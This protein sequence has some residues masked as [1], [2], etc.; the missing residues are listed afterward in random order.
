MRNTTRPV[1]REGT[2]VKQ[3]AGKRLDPDTKRREKTRLRVLQSDRHSDGDDDDGDDEQTDEETPPSLSPRCACVLCCLFYVLASVSCVSAYG[4]KGN[5][6][7]QEG[8]RRK[9]EDLPSFEIPMRILGLFLDMINRLVLL[10]NQNRHLHPHTQHQPPSLFS[11]LPLSSR[12]KALTSLNSCPNC[13]IL[14]SSLWIS[15]CRSWTSLYA[16]RAT[17][18][19]SDCATAFLKI[20][21]PPCGSSTT[22]RIS[23]GVA[24]G[25]TVCMRRFL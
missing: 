10:I 13:S 2:V 22:A 11:P 5:S 24:S 4:Q 18:Y 19:R 6:G 9:T 16:C 14:A 15:A 8:E 25:L 23:S 17:A 3:K 1:A 21:V 7:T 12:N 20:C